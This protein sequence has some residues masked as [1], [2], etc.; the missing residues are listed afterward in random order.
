MPLWKAT[1]LPNRENDDL[2]SAIVTDESGKQLIGQ[3]TSH[4]AAERVVFLHNADKPAD[5]EQSDNE[6]VEYGLRLVINLAH[7][8]AC[9]AQLRRDYQAIAVSEREYEQALD[10]YRRVVGKE[11]TA[12]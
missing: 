5:S 2:F 8:H 11:P 10:V 1:P 12:A 9:M 6:L 4:H 7:D 3:F